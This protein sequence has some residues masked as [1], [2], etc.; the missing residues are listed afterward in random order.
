MEFDSMVKVD[1]DGPTKFYKS[2]LGVV[3]YLKKREAQIPVHGN[4]HLL[5]SSS[6]CAS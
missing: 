5:L 2:W 3:K 1:K 6:L 4:T